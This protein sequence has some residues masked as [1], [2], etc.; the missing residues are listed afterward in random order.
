MNATLGKTFEQCAAPGADS[1]YIAFC[2]ASG[3]IDFGWFVPTGCIEIVRGGRAEVKR[4][5]C[6]KARHCKGGV[7]GKLLVPG[8]P[9]ASGQQAK[10]D[11]LEA[12]LVWCAKTSRPGL[13]WKVPKALERRA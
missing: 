2:W 1:P 5:M 11:A 6:V 12:F 7:P 9:E 8:I 13:T 3:L 10:G 4:A